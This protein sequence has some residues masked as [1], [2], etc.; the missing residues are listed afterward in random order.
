MRREIYILAALGFAGSVCAG[1]PGN[2]RIEVVPEIHVHTV[3]LDRSEQEDGGGIAGVCQP[4]VVAHT[5]SDFGPGEYIAQAGFVE[6]EI[7]A[8][9]YEFPPSA[10]PVKID[11]AEMLFATSGSTVTTTTEWAVHFWGGL[12][13]D[14]FPDQS[15]YSDGDLLPHAVMPPGSTGLQLQFLVDPA[16][17]KQVF[18]DGNPKNMVTVGFEIVSHHNQSGDGCF[19]PPTP[20]SNAFPTTDVDGLDSSSGNWI[21]VYDCGIFG[22]PEGWKRFSDLPTVC[23]PSGDWVQ[24]LTVTPFECEE[25]GACCIAG[26]CS[27]LDEATCLSEN[28]VFLGLNTSCVSVNCNE[29]SSCCFAVTGGCVELD[30]S[31]CLLAGGIVG[32]EGQNCANT[33]CFPIGACCLPDGS[34][35]DGQSPEDCAVLNGAFQGDGSECITTECPVPTGAA[36]FSNGF[37]LSLTEEEAIAAG[38][39]WA[40]AGTSCD[41]GDGNGIADVCEDSGLI[42]DFNG[43]NLV[44]GADLGIFLANWG[45]PGETD[46]DGNQVT[47]GA[48][49]GILLVNWTI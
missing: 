43:D 39:S 42:G 44:N 45:S 20:Q 46:L 3:V 33:V 31:N 40:G 28:G 21:K 18:I 2:Q 36:C 47:N 17:P 41:D 8:T 13:S 16:D 23:R 5:D 4:L 24:R 19:T 34:C 26:D 15:F 12:P 35:A 32:Q 11:I 27:Q 7:A 30:A 49:L 25:F 38:A 1:P 22:C 10:F 48:D 9:S 14:G 6:G 37:C 29:T